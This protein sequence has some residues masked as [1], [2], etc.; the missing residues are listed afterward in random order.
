MGRILTEKLLEQGHRVAATVRKPDALKDL[1][2]RYKDRLL[3]KTLD[4]TDT[5]AIHRVVD[6]TFAELGHIDVIVNNAGYALFGAAEE[7]TDAQIRQQFETNLFGSIQVIRAALP[8]LRK[9][10]GGHILQLSS[11]AGQTVYPSNSYYAASKWAI[12]A[13]CDTVALE[14]APF[15]INVT[16]VEPGAHPTSFGAG[17]IESPIMEAY[18]K[19]P[20]GD[21][22]RLIAAG[23]F[24]IRGDVN[25]STQAMIDITNVNPAPRR[26]ALG[27]DAYQH[28]RAALVARLEALDAQKDI[29]LAS[30]LPA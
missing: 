17:M 22:R 23:A 2:A 7:S 14:V 19:T 6:L 10:G 9:Q 12:E 27:A 21:L 5:Q 26:L 13:F 20:V 15:N 16:I 3:V 29:A 8:H 1:L 25:K 18:D 11:S 30:E 28:I 4:V 24:A